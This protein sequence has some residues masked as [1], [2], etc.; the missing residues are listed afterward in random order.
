MSPMH[1]EVTDLAGKGPLCFLSSMA[2][3]IT[4]T[5]QERETERGTLMFF[6]D[7]TLYCSSYQW[8]SMTIKLDIPIDAHHGFYFVHTATFSITVHTVVI[9]MTHRP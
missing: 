7:H 9:H 3:S 8:G 5:M 4:A 6:V 2:A 1:L